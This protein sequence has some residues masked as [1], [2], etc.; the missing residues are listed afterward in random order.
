MSNDKKSE[1]Y[2]QQAVAAVV[3]AAAQ[4]EADVASVASAAEQ[5]KEYRLTIFNGEGDNGK[6][7]VF[8]GV[9]GNGC[10]VPRESEVE[11]T[12]GVIDALGDATTRV[13]DEAGS[14]EVRRFN[15]RYERINPA[16]A[17]V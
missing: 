14:R 11:V 16:Q 8:V 12:K 10:L 5:A 2:R 1:Q 15:Y 9:N 4:Q 3:A 7:P 13:F 6:S 17:A